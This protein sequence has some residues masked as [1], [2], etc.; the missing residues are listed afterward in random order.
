MIC[1]HLKLQFYDELGRVR[2]K[3]EVLWG[4][5]HG[6]ILSRSDVCAWKVKESI[7]NVCKIC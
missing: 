6:T 2:N 5:C 7:E 4:S 1:M 3:S